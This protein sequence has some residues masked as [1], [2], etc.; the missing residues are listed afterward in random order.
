M[1]NLSTAHVRL[2]LYDNLYNKI[3]GFD[4]TKR[5]IFKEFIEAFEK[6]S[7]DGP[8]WHCDD[9]NFI[10]F[11]RWTY[12]SNLEWID[13]FEAATKL[14]RLELTKTDIVHARYLVGFFADMDLA[15]DWCGTGWFVWD[16][17]TNMM[18]H[19]F[20]TGSIKTYS[21]EN[22]LGDYPVQADNEGEDEYNDRYN[23]WEMD[24]LNKLIL[25]LPTD[26]EIAD[27]VD[28]EHR[29]DVFNVDL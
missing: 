17:A 2:S 14:L 3:D 22:S 19:D 8:G 23:N 16:M 11:G 6:I 9:N 25:E 20:D 13:L 15:M 26:I 12:Q 7:Y 5:D 1:A 27:I 10:M 4:L 29:D 24:I 28:T 21:S 18:Y